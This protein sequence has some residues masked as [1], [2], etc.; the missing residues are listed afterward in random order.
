M[1]G[2]V[3]RQWEGQSCPSQGILGGRPL[4][5]KR[6]HWQLGRWQWAEASERSGPERPPPLGL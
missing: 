3:C 4:G 2:L 6:N 1:R 5:S